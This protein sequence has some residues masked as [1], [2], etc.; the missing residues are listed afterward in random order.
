MERRTKSI[1]QAND[2]RKAKR[3]KKKEEKKKMKSSNIQCL[4]R[5]KGTKRNETKTRNKKD[6]RRGPELTKAGFL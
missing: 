2:Q 4:S 6:N 3:R 5:G 1:K